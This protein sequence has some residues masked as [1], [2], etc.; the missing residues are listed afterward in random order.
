MIDRFSS[1]A[2]EI[3]EVVVGY[4]HTNYNTKQEDF[5]AGE[6]I[7]NTERLKGLLKIAGYA[8]ILEVVTFGQ[9]LTDNTLTTNRTIY[10]FNFQWNLIMLC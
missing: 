8:E 1:A 3:N 2:V 4:P 6:W 7:E 10:Y 5:R 9:I